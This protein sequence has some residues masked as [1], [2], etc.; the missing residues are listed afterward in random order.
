MYT[1]FLIA[2]AVT[3]Q[4]PTIVYFLARMQMV[5]AHFLAKH[6]K[7]AVLIIVVV[8]A[9]ITPSGDPGTQMVFAAPMVGLYLLSIGIAWL[10]G[11]KKER[12]TD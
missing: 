4:M 7:Y 11:P 12:K 3:F 5:T 8:A 2:M 1:K 10:V 6:L 9:V